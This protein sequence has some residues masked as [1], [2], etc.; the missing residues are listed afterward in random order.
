MGASLNAAITGMLG[1]IKDGY[2]KE[3][4]NLFYI[5]FLLSQI[6]LKLDGMYNNFL[7]FL[8]DI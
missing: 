4:D 7:N 3:K 2:G 1:S 6:L 8:I 5:M